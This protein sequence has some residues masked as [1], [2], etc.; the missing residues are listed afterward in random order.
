MQGLYPKLKVCQ[1]WSY[2][3]AT[4]ADARRDFKQHHE[5]LSMKFYDS[6]QT[7]QWCKMYKMYCQQHLS[8]VQLLYRSKAKKILSQKKMRT[9]TFSTLSRRTK[10][11]F[12]VFWNFFFCS[13][14]QV[15]MTLNQNRMKL[16]S[17][18]YILLILQIGSADYLEWSV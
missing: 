17:I 5:N 4:H 7:G 8:F 2:L 3:Y 11:F 1:T 18:T 14:V 9:L 13:L 15:W 12:S 10:W 16:C 6:Q